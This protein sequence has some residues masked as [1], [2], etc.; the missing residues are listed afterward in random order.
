MSPLASL[1]KM[2]FRNRALDFLESTKGSKP[3]L[4]FPILGG[5]PSETP[6]SD[7]SK[8]QT[9]IVVPGDSVSLFAVLVGFLLPFL[10]TEFLRRRNDLLCHEILRNSSMDTTAVPAG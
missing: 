5:R 1:P 3:L 2:Y 4:G 10:S 8:M 7:E 9:D 6:I